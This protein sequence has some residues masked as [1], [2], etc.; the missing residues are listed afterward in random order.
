MSIRRAAPILLLTLLLGLAP[1]NAT[2]QP[3]AF[4]QAEQVFLDDVWPSPP[5]L[6]DRR[7]TELYVRALTRFH[8]PV[9]DLHPAHFRIVDAGK[10]VDPQDI[11]V[12]T[13]S[14]IGRGW[15]CVIAIDVSR[16]MRGEP[17]VRAK[18][19]AQS[20]LEEIDATN[21]VAIV[22][23]AN[24]SRVIAGFDMARS[25]A[26]VKLALLEIDEES[27]N[28]VLFDG[29]RQ[30]ISAIRQGTN[31]PRRAF[32]I[33]FTDG[34]DAGS[35][36]ALENVIEDA[37]GDQRKPPVLIFTIGYPRFGAGGMATLE[38]LSKQTEGLSFRAKSTEYIKPFFNQIR[39][40]MM[41][42]YVLRYPAEMDG[43]T[44]SVTVSI[45]GQSSSR[46]AVFP[47][48][49]TNYL[50]YIGI[51]LGVMILG[52]AAIFIGRG[53]PAGRL[54][55]SPPLP[56]GEIFVLKQRRTSI[57]SL[58]ENDIVIPNSAVS[59]YHAVIH[60]RGDQLEIEDLGSTNGT[61]VNGSRFRQ[62]SPL[63]PGDRI[64]IADVELVYQR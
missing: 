42:S 62:T 45:E 63:L 52:G 28:T 21:R 16:T 27:L 14:E 40:Q 17:F 24:N 5:D 51:G 25:D 37:R 30:A 12:Q 4:R 56:D 11:E 36:S 26:K 29:V 6:D 53:R 60:R 33:V 23:F 15:S 44:H 57:G 54:V 7:I 32:V 50:P 47:R 48:I 20:F 39:H 49:N 55:F 38:Q 13:L 46:T 58:P 31:L 35:E 10:V 43:E 59:K 22:T 64:R 19:A 1:A 8:E 18:A 3:L 34:N 41:M 2:G 61:F 9:D